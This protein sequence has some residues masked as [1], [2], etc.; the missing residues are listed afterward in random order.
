M[1]STQILNQFNIQLHN[2]RHIVKNGEEE[3]L[4]CCPFHS[5]KQPSFYLHEKGC[6]YYCFG[7]QRSGRIHDIIEALT[8]IPRHK[9]KEMLK[10]KIPMP[11]NIT[12]KQKVTQRDRVPNDDELNKLTMYADGLHRM[13]A[14]QIDYGHPSTAVPP[15]PFFVNM[16]VHFDATMWLDYLRSKREI[17]DEAIKHFR[18]GGNTHLN[19]AKYFEMLLDYQHQQHRKEWSQALYDLRLIRKGKDYWWKPVVVIPWRYAG[20]TYYMNA[21]MINPGKKEPKYIGMSG[22]IKSVFFNDDALDEFNEVYLVEGE[23]NAIALWD[24]GFPN[25]VSFGAKNTLAGKNQRTE[26]LLERLH[27]K[28]VILYVD[29]D[30]NDPNWET[31]SKI[32]SQLNQVCKS[33]RII[34]LPIG[35]DINDVWTNKW[36]RTD[37]VNRVLA[38]S[39]KVPSPFVAMPKG[40]SQPSQTALLL[41][42]AQ[43]NC[44]KETMHIGLNLPAYAGEFILNGNPVGVGKTTQAAEMLIV[45]KTTALILCGQHYIADVYSELLQPLG[46]MRLYGRSHDVIS[47]P[48]AQ[49]SQELGKIGQGIYFKLK[50][51]DNC[52]KYDSCL[53]IQQQQQA[54]Q[55]NVLIGT[56]AHASMIGFLTDNFYGNPAR[57]FIIVDELAPL[58]RTINIDGNTLLALIP[59]LRKVGGYLRQDPFTAPEGNVAFQLAEI[60]RNLHKNLADAKDYQWHAVDTLNKHDI[61]VVERG[62]AIRLLSDKIPKI[63]RLII[64]ELAYAINNNIP[65]EYDSETMGYRYTWRAKFPKDS[66]VIF[67]SATTPKEY[68]EQSLGIKIDRVIGDKIDVK[69]KNLHIT[70][71]M[72]ITGGRD[73]V[74]RDKTFQANLKQFFA[75]MSHKHEGQRICVLTSLKETSN[76]ASFKNDVIKLLWKAVPDNRQ[77]Y[78][79]SAKDLEKG[80]LPVSPRWIPVYHHGILGTNLLKDFD[81]LVEINAH[82]FNS[83]DVEC[84]VREVF[85]K[86][87]DLSLKQ[88]QSTTFKAMVN[89]EIVEYPSARYI[90]P[91]ADVE[92]Y[93]LAQERAVLIQGEGRVLRGEDLPLTIYRLHNVNIKPY[94]DAVYSSWKGMFLG[95]FGFAELKGRT[96]EVWDWI[97]NHA[98]HESFAVSQIANALGCD[99]KNIKRRAFQTLLKL[100]RIKELQAKAG[101]EQTYALVFKA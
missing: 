48:Y 88:K 58:A 36:T 83:A 77:F 11:N 31:R 97:L 50:Y 15:T 54:K 19:K 52:E 55:A 37:W 92:L 95:E 68:L 35:I 63:P 2:Q 26:R 5:D 56:H 44:K 76:G 46:A 62:I 34:E 87:V 59:L 1:T 30:K 21:R 9:V 66:T 96:K 57:K 69:R 18:L 65:L 84:G 93:L 78:P 49:Q 22:M 25:V 60:C 47:C 100:N 41:K 71:M 7:C 99:R 67:L 42:D 10:G 91:D 3:I 64:K 12:L 8:S 61:Y 74:L 72:N 94:P 70:Q 79:V 90:H 43:F 4:A 27:G 6:Y 101:T 13:L 20:S 86:D 98:N 29:K 75:L 53:H 82:Y 33:V 89:G 39:K 28:Q 38:N 45:A 23:F 81:V 14:L 32:V 85:G 16:P 40:K 80:K 17:T 51:C 24:I 73:K